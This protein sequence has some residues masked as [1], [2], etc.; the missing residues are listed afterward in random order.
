M[1]SKFF[2]HSD[3]NVLQQ[4]LDVFLK[5]LEEI[6]GEVNNLEML[7]TNKEI[8]VLVIYSCWKKL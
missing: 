7:H 4:E 2:K 5:E 3:V 8:I 6:T 1:H